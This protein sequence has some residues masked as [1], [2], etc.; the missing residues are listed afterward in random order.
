MFVRAVVKYLLLM[1]TWLVWSGVPDWDGEHI[2]LTVVFGLFSCALV[3]FF[4]ERMRA[5]EDLEGA[6]L[7]FWGRQLLYLPWLMKEIVLS[8]WDVAKVIVSPGLPIRPRLLRV[9]CTQQ[10]DLAKVIYANSITLTPGTITLDI[11]GNTLLVHALTRG[12]AEGLLTGEMDQ[13]VTRL[14]G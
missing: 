9:L 12:S 2:P 4:S 1:G 11:R 10:S 8:N 3:V 7:A 5:A 14:E 13:R 6:G